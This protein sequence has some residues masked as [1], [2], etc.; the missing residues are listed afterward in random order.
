[1]T[2]SR[3]RCITFSGL[4]GNSISFVFQFSL[5]I[6]SSE[7][8]SVLAWSFLH[9]QSVKGILM[10]Q[11]FTFCILYNKWSK[12]NKNCAVF[13][14]ANFSHRL[15]DLSS[16]RNYMHHLKILLRYLSH[17]I[18]DQVWWWECCDQ[19]RATS[20]AWQIAG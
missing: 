14:H 11:Y 13:S 7:Y 16:Q 3:T 4:S 8:P 9:I 6:W 19:G 18:Y 10:L 5:R 20:W 1:M 17:S 2:I 15:K 12:I